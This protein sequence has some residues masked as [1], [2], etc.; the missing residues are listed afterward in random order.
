MIS[1]ISPAKS[2]NFSDTVTVKKTSAPIFLSEA[3]K[4]VKIM[5]T[6]SKSDLMEMMELSESLAELNFM[7]FKNWSGGTHKEKCRQALFAFDGDVYTGLDA[8]NLSENELDFAQDN[9][10]ILSGMYGVL[11]PLDTIEAY[12]LEMGRS[13]ST[14]RGNNLYQ[15]WGDRIT[16]EIQKAL[17]KSDSQVLLNLASNEYFK[18][19]NTK[20]LNANIVA[21]QFKDEKNGKYKVV[22]FFAKKARGAMAR[23]VIQNKIQ[24]PDLIKAFEWEG[25]HFNSKLSIKNNWVFTR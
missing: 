23:F 17:K 7:R 25:Y 15:W 3:K 9:L 2:L 10:L 6:K 24:N 11:R 12:R 22:S 20:K 8:Y 13:L 5:K 19:V 1:L 18:S 21:P 16:D 14:E 4:L